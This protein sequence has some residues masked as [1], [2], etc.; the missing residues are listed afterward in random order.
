MLKLSKIGLASLWDLGSKSLVK[1]QYKVFSCAQHNKNK[2]SLTIIVII[3]IVDIAM[4][5]AVEVRILW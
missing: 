2:Y 3:I 4:P 1:R 5:F